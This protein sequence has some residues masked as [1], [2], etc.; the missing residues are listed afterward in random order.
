MNHPLPHIYTS[1]FFQTYLSMHLSNIPF[2]LPSSTHTFYHTYRPT[3]LL[4]T[5]LPPHILST[6]HTVLQPSSKPTFLHTYFLPHIPSYNPPPNLP[7]STHTFYHTYRPTI[8]LQT[9]L[10]PYIDIKMRRSSERLQMHNTSK[11]K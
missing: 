9:Y 6:T 11:R 8:L 10:P 5:Y 1:T 7:S 3:T 2:Y 4:Q